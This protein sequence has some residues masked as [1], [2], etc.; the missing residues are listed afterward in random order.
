MLQKQLGIPVGIVHCSMSASNIE[1]WISEEGFAVDPEV[2]A[3][4]A[5]DLADWAA[6][7]QEVVEKGAE[8]S[9]GTRTVFKVRFPSGNFNSGIHPLIPYA[10]RGV[11]WYQGEQNTG[12]IYQKQMAALMAD[13][14]K[15]W[16]MPEM[17]IV[18]A[19]ITTYG[20]TV[21]FPAGE[22]FS[23]QLGGKGPS[24]SLLESQ[25]KFAVSDRR[26]WLAP[27]VELGGALHPGTKPDIAARMVQAALV[28]VYGRPGE[29][30]GP[31]F[32]KLTRDGATV[33]IEFRHAK[34]LF[35]A[36]GLWVDNTGKVLDPPNSTEVV[37]LGEDGVFVLS[38][39]A[40]PK[41]GKAMRRR[42]NQPVRG[43]C[44]L[45]GG[46]AQVWHEVDARIEGETIVATVP[47]DATHIMGGLPVGQPMRVS[48]VY[49]EAELPM[50]NFI[51][52]LK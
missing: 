1:A 47:E 52:P 23:G 50:L 37:K 7:R 20:G 32:Q 11:A 9:K 16:G 21:P 48:N 43:I 45:K 4:H 35:A 3:A 34:G 14:R 28:N 26:A 15:R 33:R 30:T 41:S 6:M 49:N 38:N 42:P 8:I 12:E 40:G 51:E 22:K 10:I 5:K 13:W 39:V 44:V 27:N 46:N 2:A 17:P 29:G 31:M 18:F 25:R 19:Q 36:E 24:S